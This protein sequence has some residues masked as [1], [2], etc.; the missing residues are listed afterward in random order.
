MQS[1]VANRAMSETLRQV[2]DLTIIRNSR[3]EIIG[4]FAPRALQHARKY[5]EFFSRF[6]RAEIERRKRAGKKGFTT[7][8]VLQ[9]LRSLTKD[10]SLKNHLQKLI[11]GVEE[12][13]RCA[14]R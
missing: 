6:D 4:L 8:E 9:R 7:K 10:R 2:K 12:R 14:L 1:I 11:K 5:A 3:G 13:D